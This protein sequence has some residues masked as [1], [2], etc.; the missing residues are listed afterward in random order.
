VILGEETGSRADGASAGTFERLILPHSRIEVEIP[1]WRYDLPAPRDAAG[2]GVVPDV[3]L[4]PALADRLAGRDGQ[5]AAA[6]EYML[7]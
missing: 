3:E 7:R 4:R 2:R 6:I 5:R 1:R